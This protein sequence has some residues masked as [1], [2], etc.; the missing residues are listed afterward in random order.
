MPVEKITEFILD[1]CDFD[2]WAG[3]LINY[4][5]VNDIN[6]TR[7]ETLKK[8]AVIIL[9]FSS[10]QHKASFISISPVKPE[11]LAKYSRIIINLHRKQLRTDTNFI[12]VFNNPEKRK[13]I[14]LSE[15]K[16]GVN[17]QI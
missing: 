13:R 9:L 4:L 10:C 11:E 7:G 6:E 17:S 3:V 12:N 2:S 8:K 15:L 5:V 16:L 1:I 14:Y